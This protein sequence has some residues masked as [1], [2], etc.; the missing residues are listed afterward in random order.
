MTGGGGDIWGTS[1]S[2]HYVWQTMAGDGTVS[3]QVVSQT[4][5]DPYAKAGVMIRA[6]S[7][8]G[9]PYYAVYVTAGNGI[10]VQ[11]RDAVGD[12][13]VQAGLDQFRNGTGLPAD[14]QNRDD[15]QRGHVHRRGHLDAD[16]GL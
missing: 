9:S 8:P 13:A 4:V 12:N 10:V 7:D 11:S 2:F 15:V 16:T 1:D 3:S 6:S 5:T 14:H